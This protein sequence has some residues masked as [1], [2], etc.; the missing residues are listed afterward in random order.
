[1][2]GTDIDYKAKDLLH[3][4]E[5]EKDLKQR[6]EFIDKLPICNEVLY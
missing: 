3:L 6:V 5:T 2:I 4:I 1:M